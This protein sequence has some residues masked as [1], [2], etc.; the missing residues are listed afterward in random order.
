MNLD[1]INSWKALFDKEF[2][3]EY[4]VNL[5]EY[6]KKEAES[7]T[8]FPPKELIFSCFEQTAFEDVKVV[9]LGQ[10]PYHGAGQANGLSFSVAEGVPFPPSLRNIFKE[11][12]SDLGVEMP[13]SGDLSPW[14]KQGVLLLNT[15]LTVRENQ[16]A[17]HQKRGWEQLT[18]VVIQKL[19]DE[20]EHLVFILWG[21]SA[22]KK[23][24]IIDRSKHLMIESV[25][26]SPLSSY[27]GFFGS[28][29]FSKTNQYLK[30]TGKKE[31]NW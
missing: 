20:R 22:I 16:A 1:R 17:S 5:M 31:I 4:F 25:H 29:P 27:R 19:S 24:K 26:P 8:V 18:D 12:H 23:G 15:T 30:K 14:A 13:K 3:K 28:Q 11:L 6:L 10:D 2:E 7:F 9:I 21:N